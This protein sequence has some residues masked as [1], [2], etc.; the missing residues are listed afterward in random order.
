MSPT[1]SIITIT[2]RDPSGLDATLNSLKPLFSGNL[3]WEH[4]IIDD[5]PEENEAVLIKLPLNWP[6]KRLCGIPSGIYPA[7]NKGIEAAAGN[8]L[9]FL[10][11]GDCLASAE[12]FKMA[13]SS[14]QERQG[15][16]LFSPVKIESA[17]KLRT[18]NIKSAFKEN[19]LGF[20]RICHQGMIYSAKIFQA[21]GK[22]DVNFRWAADYDHHWKVLLNN[23]N[24][25]YF[26]HPFASINLLGASNRE[27]KVI[28]E[29][30]Q[31]Q[32]KY[33]PHLSVLETIKNHFFYKRDFLKYKLSRFFRA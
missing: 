18:K 16:L 13:V 6:L 4:I 27:A 24:T 7:M 14:I 32:A 25:I 15:D 23:S 12:M 26:P 5:S 2:F 22:Y 20:N 8:Y 31:I 9:W 11:G 17:G 1:I 29:F 28:D 30:K 21:L 10:N 19:I 33:V 3:S